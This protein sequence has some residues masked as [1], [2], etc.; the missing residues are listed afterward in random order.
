MEDG[1][2]VGGVEAFPQFKR[3]LQQNGCDVPTLKA[4]S[5]L[6]EPDRNLWNN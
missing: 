4:L 5:F 6:Y 1:F 2:P 3:G